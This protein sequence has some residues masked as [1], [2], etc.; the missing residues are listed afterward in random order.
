[1]SLKLARTGLTTGLAAT[2]AATVLLAGCSS[3]DSDKDQ[4]PT[5]STSSDAPSTDEPESSDAPATATQLS[6]DNLFETV[7]A[8]QQEAGSYRGTS[9][10]MS[11][12]VT[13]SSTIETTYENGE[14]LAH[15]QTLPGSDQQ[16][17]IVIAAGVAY[18]KSDSFPVPDGKWLTIDPDDPEVAD[19]PFAGFSAA[20][21]P[22]TSLKILDEPEE[23]TLVGEETIEGVDTSHYRVV[24]STASYADAFGLAD[25]AMAAL[26][27]ELTIELWVDADN[28]LVKQ[29]QEAELAGQPFSTETTY[30]DYG[31]DISVDVPAKADTVSISEL[32]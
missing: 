7:F 6:T 32:G 26:P 13:I 22:E 9:T 19:S 27:D 30:T 31:A 24:I 14:M 15:A 25:E 10:T 23:V 28:R 3:D 17:E 21:D 8:A 4:D 16:L 2:L 1:M 20:F 11:G 29:A 5:T 18:L 12:G